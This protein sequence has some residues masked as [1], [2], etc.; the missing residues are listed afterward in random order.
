MGCWPL[1]KEQSFTC[2]VAQDEICVFIFLLGTCHINDMVMWIMFF[3]IS[4]TN[5]NLKNNTNKR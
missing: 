4:M 1:T 5:T 2:G 3:S